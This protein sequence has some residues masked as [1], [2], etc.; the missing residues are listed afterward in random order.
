MKERRDVILYDSKYLRVF[1]TFD[2]FGFSMILNI[3]YWNLILRIGT[4]VFCIG[5]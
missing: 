4:I 2:S 3:D 1:H 5:R